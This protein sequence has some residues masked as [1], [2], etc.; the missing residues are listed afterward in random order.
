MHWPERNGESDALLKRPLPPHLPENA[1]FALL[2][3]L[4]SPSIIALASEFHTHK[5]TGGGYYRNT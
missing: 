4:S 2:G 1:N 3:I 5:V